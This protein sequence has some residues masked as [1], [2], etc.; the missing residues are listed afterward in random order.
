MDL[1]GWREAW[2]I[3][4]MNP[5]P[6]GAALIVFASCSWWLRGYLDKGQLAVKDGQLRIKDDR[7]ELAQTQKE[8][9]DRKLANTQAELAALKASSSEPSGLWAKVDQRLKEAM[10]TSDSL[11]VTLGSPS[12]TVNLKK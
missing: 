6:F 5:I 7:L 2:D 11:G 4:M 12:L 3:F 8:D 1:A 10:V 9:L